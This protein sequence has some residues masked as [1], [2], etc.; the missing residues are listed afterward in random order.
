M[1][2]I[3][4]GANELNLQE[5]E[6]LLADEAQPE[7]PPVSREA[8]PTN[9]DNTDPNASKGDDDVSKTKAFAHRLKE[10]TEKARK[11]EREAI[12]KSLGYESYEAMQQQRE[13]KLMTDKGLDPEQ[14]SPVI[15]ELVQKRINDDPRMKELEELRKR[16]VAEFA[17][18]QLAELKEL[19]DGE[20]TSL[21]QLSDD[22]IKLFSSTGDLK[23][24]YIQVEGANL[25]NKLRAKQSKGST[26]H[27]QNPNGSTGSSSTA[28][29]L[30]QEEK[31]I[32]KFFNPTMTDEELNN[33]KVENT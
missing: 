15:E 24:A 14:V 25:I 11:E 4:N 32:W 16:Q 28:R 19:T 23:K 12:A 29:H 21:N 7:T 5:I 10:S 20:V 13:H 3:I 31:Q 2:D 1:E 27:L 17:K 33:K 26:D 6:A 30:T 8:A 18:Q 9:T 22:V